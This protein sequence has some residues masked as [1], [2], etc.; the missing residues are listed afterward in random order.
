MAQFG[1]NQSKGFLPAPEGKQ[2]AILAE[3]SWA[4]VEDRFEGKGLQLKMFWSFQLQAE[5]DQ[6]ERYVVD[7]ELF[8]QISPNNKVGKLCKTSK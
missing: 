5:N 3:I 7:L 4:M 8:P 6:G 2:P 1:L